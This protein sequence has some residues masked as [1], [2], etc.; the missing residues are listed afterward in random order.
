VSFRDPNA[1]RAGGYV[2]LVATMLVAIGLVFHPV[3]AGGFEE[4]P[5]VLASTPWWGPIHIAIAAGFVLIVLGSLLMLVAGTQLASA[6]LATFVALCWGAMTVGMIFFTGV[7]LVNGWVM[8]FL[9]A[10]GAP[11]TEPL[12]YDAFNRLLIGYGWLGNPL[13][14]VGLTGIAAV[15][16]RTRSTGMPVGLAWGGLVVAV[17]SWGRGIG[18][19]TGLFFLEPL[20]YANVPAF[21][22]LGY[23]GVL[24]ARR[25]R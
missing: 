16:V 21:L 12:L 20:I 17:L 23:Y 2:L 18:S 4:R 10:H 1:A 22:W 6:R 7:A 11:S 19:A 8:H 25:A 13:F 24:S 15:E 5:S 9:T 3:P 14:L